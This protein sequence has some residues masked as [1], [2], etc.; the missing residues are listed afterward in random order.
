MKR[1]IAICLSLV[2]PGVGLA[3]NNPSTVSSQSAPDTQNNQE[4]LGPIAGYRAQRDQQPALAT[5]ISSSQARQ[6]FE[7]QVGNMQLTDIPLISIAAYAL[8]AYVGPPWANIPCWPTT[9][10]CIDNPLYN[11]ITAQLVRGLEGT[12]GAVAP[13]S[14][15]AQNML[16]NQAQ[17]EEAITTIQ[18]LETKKADLQTQQAEYEQA[19]GDSSYHVRLDQAVPGASSLPTLSGHLD[20]LTQAA[21]LSAA[22]ARQNSSD[23]QLQNQLF[24]AAL[25]ND[26]TML[27][28]AS[29]R[30]AQEAGKTR[31]LNEM[32]EVI[33]N[34][35]TLRAAQR[36]E[37][38]R[39]QYDQEKIDQARN[40]IPQQ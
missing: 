21:M 23:I 31:A 20:S 22:Q 33:N 8:W 17:Q 13:G 11:T 19:Y 24:Y 7:A 27:D 6:I 25:T 16:K 14:Q 5:V 32:R 10:G 30:N 37:A 35:Q 28:R 2:L 18:D 3:Q 1:V 9:F 40:N 39:K 4:M 36:N 29:L 34:R 26:G 12:G 15:Q 38:A